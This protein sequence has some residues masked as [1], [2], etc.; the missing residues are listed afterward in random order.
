VAGLLH[1]I[2]K[3]GIPD[4]VLN[5]PGQLTGEEWSLVRAHPALGASILAK[6]PMLSDIIPIVAAHHERFDGRGYPGN[7]AGENIPLAARILA[8]ADAY[9]A[10]TSNRPYRHAMSRQAAL[11]ELRSNAG[12]Q[13]DP[14]IVE[15]VELALQRLAE[16][17]QFTETR[18]PTEPVF[19]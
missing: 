12:T 1:D 8:V 11:D 9:D 15:V 13:F 10:M 4:N 3:I 14:N 16:S 6:A 19:A 18:E 17:T 2:G 5:K 7:A